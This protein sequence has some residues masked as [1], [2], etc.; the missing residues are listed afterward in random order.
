VLSDSTAAADR[1]VKRAEY[2]ALPSIQRYV[3]L[4]QYERLAVV[5]D[6]EGEFQERVVRD[7][8]ALPEIGVTIRLDDLYH[9]LI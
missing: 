4:A 8:L 7:V 2:A 6:R 9:G 3:I 1:G 5:C